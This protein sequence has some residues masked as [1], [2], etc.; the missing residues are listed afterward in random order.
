[1]RLHE[2]REQPRLKIIAAADVDADI[3]VDPLAS[4]E[5]GDGVGAG[6]GGRIMQRYAAVSEALS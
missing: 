6:G 4:V 3:D 1:M 2:P 5:I